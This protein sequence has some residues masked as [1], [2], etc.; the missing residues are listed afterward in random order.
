MRIDVLGIA[1]VASL[2]DAGFEF[3]V[4]DGMLVCSAR[5]RWSRSVTVRLR[6]PIR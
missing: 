6:V 2:G 3:R 1:G 4:N 5:R